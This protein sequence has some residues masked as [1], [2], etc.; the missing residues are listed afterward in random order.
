MGGLKDSMRDAIKQLA[1]RTSVDRLKK[2]GVTQVNVLGLD[3]IAALIEAAVHRSLKSRLVGADREV[4]ADA[5]KAEFL[6]LLRSNEDLLREKSEVERMRERAEEELDA[7]RRDLAQQQSALKLKLERL[8]PAAAGRWHGEDG[9]IAG[10]VA[11]IV[12]AL[13]NGGP[14]SADDV[15]RRLTELVMDVVSDERRDAEAA[16]QALIDRDVAAMQRRIE[17]LTGS[18]S[19]TEHKLQ[20]LSAQHSLDSGI[21]S[22]YREVQGLAP[23]DERAETK[24]G[25]M[26]AILEANLRLQKRGTA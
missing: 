5:T 24:K 16:R 3:R 10:K 4:V 18:L 1:F 6:R 8:D 20:Q 11:A 26:A 17:K 14:T 2:Q 12:Q 15:Q 23:D 9:A 19:L 13:A 25:M 22:I 7:L 21:S